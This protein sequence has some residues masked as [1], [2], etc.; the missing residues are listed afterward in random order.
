MPLLDIFFGLWVILWLTIFFLLVL[1][2]TSTI[3]YPINGQRTQRTKNRKRE[4]SGTASTSY[5]LTMGLHK[6]KQD[7][8]L[9]VDDNYLLEHDIKRK[10]LQKRKNSVVGHTQRA[11]AACKELL[12]VV[13]E[14]LTRDYPESFE[15]CSRPGWQ[16]GLR[17][18]KIDCVEILRFSIDSFPRLPRRQNWNARLA[19]CRWQTPKQTWRIYFASL[20]HWITINS[21]PMFHRLLF[22]A[23][24]KHSR[25]LPKT[26][27]IVFAVKTSLKALA[28]LTPQELISFRDEVLT[29]P[30]DVARYKGRHCWG[31][32]ALQ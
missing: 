30:E 12:K 10:L 24:D 18:E 31:Q 5:N 7:K 9:T 25:E 23:S 21:L 22:V 14:T 17:E 28:E 32:C 15:Y 19:L 29:W 8:W 6:P 20:H 26:G 1:I 3:E 27:A 11:E 4:A 16:V 2:D 13:A